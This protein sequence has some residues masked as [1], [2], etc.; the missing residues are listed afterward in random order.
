MREISLNL[1]LKTMRESSQNEKRYCFILG[2]GASR[3]SGIRT[4]EEMAR[5]WYLDLNSRYLPAELKSI[6]AELDITDIT[7]SSR[8]YFDL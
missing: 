5:E 6:M 2:A 7:P 8:S 4:G 1:F 3:E